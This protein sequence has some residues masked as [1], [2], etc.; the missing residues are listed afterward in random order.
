VNHG[1]EPMAYLDAFPLEHVGEIHLAGFDEIRDDDGAPL[2]VDAHGCPVAA[3]VWALYARVLGRAGPIPTLIEWD[4][5]VPELPILETQVAGAKAHL[6]GAAARRARYCGV[7]D[8]P[9][10]EQHA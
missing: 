9:R 7:S 8:P 6:I 3:T 10:E 5:D 4:N 2:L 1:F